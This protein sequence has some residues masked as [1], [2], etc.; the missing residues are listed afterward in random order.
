MPDGS[1][2]LQKNVVKKCR[3]A[4]LRFSKIYTDDH[5]HTYTFGQMNNDEA[6]KNPFKFLDISG[7]MTLKEAERA[8]NQLMEEMPLSFHGVLAYI[9]KGRTTVDEL[10]KRIPISRRTLL[11]LRT[12]ER[13]SYKL[14]QVI[15]ICIGL[16]LP[17]WLSEI[18]LDKAGLSVKRYGTYGYYGTILDCFYMDTIQDVQK[19]LSENGYDPLGLFFEE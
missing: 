14:D 3:H 12:E 1:K 19:Y 6:L 15:A 17:P 7:S 4:S 18:L 16:H 8:K 13:K 5:K 10:V 2:H 11:R 9:M